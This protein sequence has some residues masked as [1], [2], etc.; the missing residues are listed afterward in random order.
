MEVFIPWLIILFF[1]CICIA[2]YIRID[3][4][5]DMVV[6][7]KEIVNQLLEE[8]KQDEKNS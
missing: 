1:A 5:Q 4:L 6:E 2:M 7:M 8:K 3:N